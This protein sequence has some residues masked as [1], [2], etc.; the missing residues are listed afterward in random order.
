M[1]RLSDRRTNPL[2][3]LAR[4][5]RIRLYVDRHDYRQTVLL[6]G[7][8]R[9][10]TT[11]LMELL[12]FDD[13]YRSLFEPLHPR[14]VADRG[15]RPIQ[16]LQPGNLDPGYYQPLAAVLAGRVRHS[17]T[18]KFNRKIW[19]RQRLIKCIHANLLLKWVKVNFPEVPIVLLLRHPCAVANSRLKLGLPAPIDQF[20]AQEPLLADHLAPFAGLL[21]TA[22]DPFERH[23][24]MWCVEHYVPLRQLGESERSLVFYEHLVSRPASELERLCAFVG[25][26]YKPAMQSFVRRPSAVTKSHSAVMTGQDLVEGWRQAIRPAQVM[27]AM[28]RLAAFGLDGLYG[29]E[30]WPL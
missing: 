28:D 12:N 13:H 23:I 17:W 14:L 26:P 11:W 8:A 24:L 25:R 2:V 5:I 15:F 19:V 1:D 10:G 6:A 20:L 29:P 9:S 27:L 30:G 22:S 16:Y 4:K 21:Q 3:R 7:T 18:D